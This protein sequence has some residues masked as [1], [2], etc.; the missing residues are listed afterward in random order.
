MTDVAR[1]L[2]DQALNLPLAERT[3]MVA[4]LMVSIDGAAD[5]E[6][7]AAWSA[8]IQRRAARVR[9]GES[10]GIPWEQVDAE[11]EEELSQQ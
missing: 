1:K 3:H 6:A 4:E 9:S 11:I 5:Q 10:K 2:L 8:E 7:R